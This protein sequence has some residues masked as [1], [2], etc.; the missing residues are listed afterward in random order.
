MTGCAE[1]GATIWYSTSPNPKRKYPLSWELTETS[2]GNVICVNTLRANQLAGEAIGAQVITELRGYQ[3]LASEVKYGSENSRIDFLLTDPARKNCFVEV[4]SVTLEKSNG[5]GYFPDAVS[6][7]GQK[8][9]RELMSEAAQGSRAVLLFVVLH[10]G[11][12][13]VSPAD[14]IDPQYALLLQ[15]AIDNG[16][17]VITWGA[18]ITSKIMEINAPISFVISIGG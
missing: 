13:S 3:H 1:P 10:S 11:I 17:E 9:L 12:K 6:L 18:V 4:K 16:V 2:A 15:Q 14:F 5:T 7:R 8:H